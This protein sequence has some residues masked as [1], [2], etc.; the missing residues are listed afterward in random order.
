[1]DCDRVSAEAGSDVCFRCR[2]RR[3]AG[4]PP[5]SEVRRVEGDRPLSERLV[6]YRGYYN[7]EVPD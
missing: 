5:L 6:H 3:D 7:G 4:E 2:R 1:V